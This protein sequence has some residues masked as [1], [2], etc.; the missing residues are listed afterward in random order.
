MTLDSTRRHRNEYQEYFLGGERRPVPMADNLNTVMCLCNKN[1]LDELFTLSLF[2]Q[3]T[4][5]I[6]G[7]ICSPSSGGILYIYTTNWYMLCFSVACLLAGL[8][9]SSIP[10]RP[11]DRQLKS[12]TRTSLLCVCVCVC[13]YIYICVC[14][15]DRGSTVVKVLCYK[16]E[17]RGFDPSWCQWIFH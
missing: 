17:G 10:T 12:K 4:S 13:I 9:W 8:G 15:G 1:Q 6:S 5:T 2:R 3:L 7:H 16:S 14:K 11:T